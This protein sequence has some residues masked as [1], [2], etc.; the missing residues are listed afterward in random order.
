MSCRY[1]SPKRPYRRVERKIAMAPTEKILQ[2]ARSASVARL[3]LGLAAL[4]RP[5]YMTLHHADDLEGRYDPTV[6]EARAHSVLDA[7]YAGGIRYIDVARSY[8]CAEAFLASWI[9]A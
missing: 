7:A 5:G 3:G 1:S 4:G 8:G 6:M 9:A 2:P